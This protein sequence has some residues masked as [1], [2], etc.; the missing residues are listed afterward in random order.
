PRPSLAEQKRSLDRIEA[1][2]RE[3]RDGPGRVAAMLDA[4]EAI[5]SA[6]LAQVPEPP[7]PPERY[8]RPLS[9]A[10][11]AYEEAQ[12]AWRHKQARP[13]G[14]GCGYCQ[15]CRDGGGQWCLNR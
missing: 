11:L 3:R 10:E 1:E 6:M 14:G 2:A 12:A 4:E 8:G 15:V 9:T 13:A 5:I 7:P